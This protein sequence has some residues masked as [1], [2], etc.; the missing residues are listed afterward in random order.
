MCSSVVWHVSEEPAASIFR[1]EMTSLYQTTVITSQKIAI[2]FTA[3]EPQS[4]KN[5]IQLTRDNIPLFM[6]KNFSFV[7]IKM[8]TRNNS[9]LSFPL[10]I[11]HNFLLKLLPKLLSLK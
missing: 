11:L 6:T 8:L 4:H 10:D 5:I 3:S 1:A 2:I 7:S 9:Q